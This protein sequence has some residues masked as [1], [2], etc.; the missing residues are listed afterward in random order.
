MSSPHCDRSIQTGGGL[1]SVPLWARHSR[2]AQT[3]LEVDSWIF[4]KKPPKSTQTHFVRVTFPCFLTLYFQVRIAVLSSCIAPNDTLLTL[5]ADCLLGKSVVGL[6]VGEHQ[7]VGNWK[8]MGSIVETSPSRTEGLS[9][10]PGQGP[11]IP[12]V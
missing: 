6:V 7:S 3:C 12:H 10:T 1:V 4:E 8:K 2:E 5:G 9:S 11:K